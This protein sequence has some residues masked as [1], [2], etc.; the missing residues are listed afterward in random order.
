M[1]LILSAPSSENE[2]IFVPRAVE[3]LDFQL[4]FGTM[5]PQTLL[6]RIQEKYTITKI[7]NVRSVLRVLLTLVSSRDF[8][9]SKMQETF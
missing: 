3:M 7:R 5:R 4:S 2:I 1:S 9:A 6:G 8:S